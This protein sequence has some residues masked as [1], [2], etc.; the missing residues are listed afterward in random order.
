MAEK[1]GK[2]KAPFK[3]NK[4]CKPKKESEV[5]E[6]LEKGDD[7]QLSLNQRHAMVTA[8]GDVGTYFQKSY[9]VPK[10]IRWESEET[11]LSESQLRKRKEKMG[12]ERER[13]RK[14]GS[15]KSR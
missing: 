12:G 1:G 9:L 10:W 3:T 7:C 5:Y 8:P 6:N 2:G 11:S 13:S 4:R 15:R 14:K